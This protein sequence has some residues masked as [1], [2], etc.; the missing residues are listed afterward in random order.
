MK[1][2]QWTAL[3]ASALVLM[4]S[5]CAPAATATPIPIVTLAPSSLE[6]TSENVKASAHV[7]P[8]QETRLSFLVPGTIKEM[9][10]TE[11]EIVNAGQMLAI[12]S[13]PDLEY[14]VQQAEAVVREAEFNYEY[15]KLPRRDGFQIVERGPVAAQELEVSRRSLD[16]A[17]ARLSQTELI[18]PFAATVVSVK[19]KTGEYVQ[20]GQIIIELAKLDNL[21]IETIDLSE[22]NIDA[23][24]IGQIATV[25]VEALDE[26][27][28]GEVTAISPISD[29]IG[30]D[31]VYKVTINLDKQPADL[32]WGMS[33]DVEIQTE[34]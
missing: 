29:T 25:Y 31:V 9:T 13:S 30:G 26:E 27:Y 19:V 3:V 8:A 33:A 10:V 32:L 4:I 34:Q 17:N 21:Q 5:S 7:V 14:G 22:L 23:V 20:P 6:V 12:L 24:E 18:T 1:R 11:G 2:T 15:W 28:P 16:T